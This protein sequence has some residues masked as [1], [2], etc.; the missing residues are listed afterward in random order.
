[1][2][3]ASLIACHECDLLLRA[4][5]P[6]RR[7]VAR[8]TRCGALLFRSNPHGVDTT[9]ALA[10]AGLVLFCMSNLFPLFHFEM[11]GLETQTTLL[12]AVAELYRQHHVLIAIVVAVTAV[13]V[14]LLRLLALVYLL[15]PLKMG[16]VPPR[17]A[18]ALRLLRLVQPW[19][20][21]EVFMLGALVSVAKLAGMAN[22]TPGIALWSF[23]A[24][25]FVLAGTVTSL[26]LRAIWRLVPVR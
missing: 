22:V 21:M 7:S 18:E 16:H 25:I 8:C 6:Q 11:Q 10:V 2:D 19:G 4:P 15:A 12:A 24:L 9:L 14:P 13:F 5:S 17:A 20:M 26:D 3:V 23:G 1:M